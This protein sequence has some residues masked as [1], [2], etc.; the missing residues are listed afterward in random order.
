MF[1]D[2]ATNALDSSNEKSIVSNLNEYFK[3]QTM[4][5]IAHRL[6]TVMDADQIVVLDQGR[7]VEVGRHDDLI[8][9]RGKYYGFVRNQMLLDEPLYE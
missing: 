9:R 6:S 8:R 1:F 7:I 4:I 5:V 3:G 2:E